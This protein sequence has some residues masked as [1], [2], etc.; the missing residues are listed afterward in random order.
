MRAAK[1]VGE[2]ASAGESV[3]HHEVE[4]QFDAVDVRPVERWL[5]ARSE[6]GQA[7]PAAGS[8]SGSPPASDPGLQVLE[9]G[10]VTQVDTYADTPDWRVHRSGYSLRLRKKHGVSE[11]TLKS[12]GAAS[13]GLRRRR[14]VTQS[15][16]NGDLAEL[17]RSEG[18]VGDRIR[19]LAGPTSLI[20]LFEVRTRRR[21]FDLSLAGAVA[22]EVVLDETTIPLGEGNP[23]ARLKRVEVEVAEPFVEPL[24]AFVQ[25]MRDECGLHPATL[26]KYEA[27]LLSRGL[28]PERPPDLGST[29]IDPF[30]VGE[31]AFAVMRQHFE[32]FLAREP[33]TRLGE[34]LEDVHDMRVA[35]RRL[36]AAIALFREALPVRT[37]RLRE[38]LSWVAQAL[39]AVRDLDVQL[40]QLEVWSDGDLE[41]EPHALKP[42]HDL[43]EEERAEARAA[44]LRALDSARHARL[45]DGFT[46]LLRQGP[47]RRSP[48]SRA[49]IATVAPELLQRR[50]RAVRKAGDRIGEGATAAEYHKLR[51][52]GKRLRYALEFLTEVTPYDTDPLVKRLVALQDLLGIQQ[53]ADVAT[54]RLSELATREGGV[55]PVPTVFAMGA[56]AERYA[57]RGRDLRGRFPK[58]YR[59]IRGRR[60]K[61]LRAVRKK[62]PAAQT[63]L[64][65]VP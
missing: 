4:W 56:L 65:A 20:P 57:Q 60:W 40:D 59:R 24:S 6:E 46:R 29:A 18:P 7:G 28:Q 12:F 42:L 58:A 53:D 47:L 34:D 17:Q 23:P 61:E 8:P 30:S 48:A 38:E 62:P 44:L 9:A 51:I 26:S 36:R 11:A 43:L 31:V 10:T 39:G 21:S 15:V 41:S 19:A 50:Y 14:E 37:I 64:R 55:L 49:P 22:G 35:S 16:S 27:G 54:S 2:T 5:Q 52:R 33:G 63:G 32:V 25:A 13:E 1:E 3:D 45:V